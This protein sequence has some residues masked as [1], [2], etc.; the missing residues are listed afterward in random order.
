MRQGAEVRNVFVVLGS[1]H[2]GGCWMTGI[3]TP[4]TWVVVEEE[5]RG[6]A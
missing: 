4:R 6:L 5:L 1:D 2:E 3:L